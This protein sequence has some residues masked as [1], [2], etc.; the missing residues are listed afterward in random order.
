[1]SKYIASI[2]IRLRKHLRNFLI[3]NN[4]FN[5]STLNFLVKI[6]IWFRKIGV[7]DSYKDGKFIFNELTFFYRKE[8]S[9]LAEF[10][11]TNNDY[12]EETRLEITRLLK[13]GSVFFDLGANIGFYTIISAKIVE[14]SGRVYSF[15]PT[16][17]TRSILQ[18]NVNINNLNNVI[19]EEYAISDKIGKAIFE[20]TN[21]SECNNIVDSGVSG[22]NTIDVNTISIDE[23]CNL[24]SISVIDVIKIDIEGQELRAI[25]GMKNIINLNLDIKLI[26]EF[27][28]AN[29]KKN[30]ESVNFFFNTLSDMGF[31]KFK[32]LLTPPIEFS[33]NDNLDFI[34][35]LAKRYNLNILAY[36]IH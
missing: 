8:D 32:I 33:I 7:L 3:A 30:N 14:S 15:E 11:I 21:N 6:D 12:E 18:K 9:G 29:I 4:V 34:N 20:V 17:E 2:Y 22:Q 35:D 23:Y 13:P 36:K 10:I 5:A 19:I 1:M 25:K 31:N 26:F 27:H 16:P 24:K 28:A